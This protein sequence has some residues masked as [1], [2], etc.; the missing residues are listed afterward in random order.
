MKIYQKHDLKRNLAPIALFC[1]NRP[2]HLK[3]T[4]NNLKKNYL[5]KNSRIYIFSDAAKNNNDL[6]KV[7][8][9]RSIIKNLEGFK[10]KKL[11]FRN[12][13]YGLAKNI[14]DGL[15]FIFNREEKIIVL[16]DDL[17]TSKYFLKYMNTYLNIY[18]NNKN[19]ASIHGYIYPIN[20]TNLN[21]NFFIR[22]ADCWGWGTWRRA[23]VKYQGDTKKLLME[24]K[25]TNQIRQFN[26]NNSKNYYRMLKKNLYTSNKSWAVQWYASAFLSNMLTL[27]P[28][29]TYIK[30]IGLD[31]SGENTKINYNLNTRFNKN[32]KVSK[33]N[34]I[35]ESNIGRKK[36]EEYFRKNEKNL[37][38]KIFYKLING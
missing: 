35:E 36:L 11:I 38:E 24:L 33:I 13:N 2:S 15:N 8:Q 30:N 34:R 28:K 23:W 19:I 29:Y 25:K 1:F 18:L 5:S 6:L 14:V 20:K 27:Y 16:E 21:D 37:I 12:K 10:E 7:D 31:G 17:I 22:G 4:I 9:V 3:K 26:F 32:Y